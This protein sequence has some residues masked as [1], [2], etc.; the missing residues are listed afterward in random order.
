MVVMGDFNYPGI[1]LSTPKGNDAR[2]DK[3]V[4]LVMDC[5]L[6]QHV[7]VPTKENNI[8][9]LVLTSEIQIKDEIQIM[10]PVDNC[11]YNI[12]IWEIQCGFHKILNKRTKLCFNQADYD[13]MCGFVSNKLHEIDFNVMSATSMWNKFNAVMQEA[14]SQFVPVST[15]NNRGKKPLWMTKRC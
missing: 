9:D 13:G 6:E 2:G 4:K 11:D 15:N 7:H 12:L 10:A 14:I 5:F 3:F 1:S 8:L